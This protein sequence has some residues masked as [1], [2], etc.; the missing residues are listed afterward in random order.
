MS[1]AIASAEEAIAILQIDLFEHPSQSVQEEMVRRNRLATLERDILVTQS[2][3]DSDA[4][5]VAAAVHAAEEE[6][7][8]VRTALTA[9][10]SVKWKYHPSK[11]SAVVIYRDDPYSIAVRSRQHVP[12]KMPT[13]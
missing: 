5:E 13:K 4:A 11:E 8:A 1:L 3:L 7:K 2:V 10:A 9:V 6:T 12:P